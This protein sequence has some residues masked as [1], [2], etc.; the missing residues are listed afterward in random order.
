MV[1]TV[2]KFEPSRVLGNPDQIYP[3]A[4]RYGWK[5]ITSQV[6]VR[7]GGAT[8]PPWEQI[9]SGPFYAYNFDVGD[10]CWFAFHVPHD[11]VPNSDVHFHAHWIPSGTNA[12]PVKWEWIYSYQKGFNQGAFSAT[13]TTVTAE[14]AGPGVAYQH[15]V[16]ETSAVTI[17][18]LTEPDG[19]VYVRLRRVANGGTDNTD[20]IFLLT[21]DI[22]YQ[23]TQQATAG[24]APNFYKY[25]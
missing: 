13:G 19:I 23:T 25:A 6:I 9:G 8:D 3:D 2:E 12:Q 15:M 22:H 20:S 1:T 11:I 14:Q 4:P 18:G 16:T 17:S 10:M 21:S 24:K 7:G 5:D